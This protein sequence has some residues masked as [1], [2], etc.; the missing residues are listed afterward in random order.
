[1]I[2]N[3]QALLSGGFS[4]DQSSPSLTGPLR[5][6][7]S[8]TGEVMPSDSSNAGLQFFLSLFL[9]QLSGTWTIKASTTSWTFWKMLLQPLSLSLWWWTSSSQHLASSGPAQSPDPSGQ[10]LMSTK[11]RSEDG[12]LEWWSPKC[13]IAT[14]MA[15]RRT[16]HSVT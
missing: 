4:L 11:L 2:I 5:S 3:L 9:L 12:P 6:A 10:V 1:M 13:V 14:E 15:G 8:C 16:R 7:P